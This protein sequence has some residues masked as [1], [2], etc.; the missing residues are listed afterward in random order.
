MIYYLNLIRLP[1]LLLCV[2]VSTSCTQMRTE[3]YRNETQYLYE[4]GCT[5]YKQGEYETAQK[6]LEELITLDPDYGPAYAVLGNLAMIDEQYELAY[7]RYQLAISHDPELE[8]DILPFLMVSTMHKARKPLIDSGVD[9]AMIYP[10]MMDEKILE[11][12]T[13][14]EQDIPLEILAKDSVSITP[15][16]LGELRA[17]GAELVPKMEGFANLQ[18]F[19]AYLL[20]YGDGN[21]SIVE[22][23]LS[24]MIQA[25][26][27]SEKQETSVLMGRLQE[28]QGNYIAAAKWYLA[29]VQAGA[30]IEDVAHHLAKIYQV[31]LETILPPKNE[32]HPEP[33]NAV[34]DNAALRASPVSGPEERAV[35]SI[36]DETEFT[37]P[38]PQAV[39]ITSPR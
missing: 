38:K 10:L 12:E 20:F 9:L 33:D 32:V 15:G 35:L 27:G 21:E 34:V 37:L 22:E 26:H 11:I 29:A 8:K 5:H 28:K 31:D 14:L 18:L 3:F 17:K 39:L 24:T 23:L 19:T 1:M 2:L 7:D 13:L 36:D 6:V 30:A 25:A 16:Q 4:M